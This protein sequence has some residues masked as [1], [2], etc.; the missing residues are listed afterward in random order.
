MDSVASNKQRSMKIKA[1]P[2]LEH[3]SVFRRLLPQ[4]RHSLSL[5]EVIDDLFAHKLL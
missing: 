5:T 2:E 3:V 4:V 1:M